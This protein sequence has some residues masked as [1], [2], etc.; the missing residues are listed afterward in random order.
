MGFP[1]TVFR[2]RGAC[3]F[4]VSVQILQKFKNPFSSGEMDWVCNSTL[5]EFHLKIIT[6][7]LVCEYAFLRQQ[8]SFYENLI[9][10]F[11]LHTNSG[12]FWDFLLI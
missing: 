10:R 4:N 3:L 2:L 5:K 9:V 12:K 6:S 7:V 8:P 11:Q 1:L